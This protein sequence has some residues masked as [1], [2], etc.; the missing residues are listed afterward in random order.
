MMRTHRTLAL[1]ILLGLSIGLTGCPGILGN[2]S[3]EAN[4]ALIQQFYDDVWN[5]HDSDA[6]EQFF[7]LPGYVHHD[8]P[9]ADFEATAESLR[10]RLEIALTIVPDVVYTVH[11]L[12][13][14]GD[15]VVARWTATG[16]HTGSIEGLPAT[17]EV[18]TVSGTTVYLISGG[19]VD[20]SWN[21]QDNLQLQQQF[22][23]IT[24]TPN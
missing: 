8:P 11:E 15:K 10:Q 9:G 12:I 18:V 13:A 14:E 5:A 24:I 21:A 16:T 23:A 6:S 20:E 17:G 22:G 19:K 7:N 4:K 1:T 3:L 2:G